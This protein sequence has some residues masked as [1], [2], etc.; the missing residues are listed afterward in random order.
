MKFRISLKE[1]HDKVGLSPYIVGRKLNLSTNTVR[2][3]VEEDEVFVGKLEADVFMKLVNF[4]GVDW[5]DPEVF[6]IVK[7]DEDPESE[8]PLVARSQ[9]EPVG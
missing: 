2:R 5:R 4:Y 7:D 3:Y 1:A 6:T 8:T 9:L